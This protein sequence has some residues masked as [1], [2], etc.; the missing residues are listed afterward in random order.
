MSR[1]IFWIEVAWL[2]RILKA[3]KLAFMSIVAGEC[4]STSI[5]PSSSK[6]L[7]PIIENPRVAWRSN[8]LGGQAKRPI[9]PDFSQ[10]FSP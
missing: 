7:V 10:A 9:E 5:I 1:I 3:T 2:L 6:Q 4:S 8:T